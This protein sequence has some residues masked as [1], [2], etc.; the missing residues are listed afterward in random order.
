MPA[1]VEAA[2]SDSRRI[3]RVLAG[4]LLLVLA[5]LAL[6][7]YVLERTFPPRLLGDEMY[8][9]IVASN[10]AAGRGHLYGENARALRPPAHAWLL[11]QVADPDALRAPERSSRSGRRGVRLGALRPLL[12]VEVALGTALVVASAVL[13]WGLFDRRTG[14]LAGAIATVYPTFIAFSWALAVSSWASTLRSETS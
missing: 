11:S 2:D 12:A 1:A 10:L 6:R 8:Y 9:V 4:L 5:A 13:A 14:L 7:V 3:V